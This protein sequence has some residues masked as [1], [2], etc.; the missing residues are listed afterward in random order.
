MVEF[1]CLDFGVLECVEKHPVTISAVSMFLSAVVVLLAARLA[2]RGARLQGQSALEAAQIQ[3]RSALDTA[4][5]QIDHQKAMQEKA[6]REEKLLIA[7]TMKSEIDFIL[8]QMA[9]LI[10][11]DDAPINHHDFLNFK[12]PVYEKFMGEI[13]ILGP[14]FVFSA[15]GFYS[16]LD[17]F[18]KRYG[19]SFNSENPQ[20]I[21][22]AFSLNR[23]LGGAKDDII[24][25]KPV[26]DF[27]SAYLSKAIADLG[28]SAVE[29]VWL[30]PQSPDQDP[31]P[32]AT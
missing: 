14:Q 16:L 19:I 30:I 3:A 8:A 12:F 28:G 18:N 6:E 15:T 26:A 10:E 13:S 11:S 22:D 21:M 25:M 32:T 23:S 31:G 2:Y 17:K 7:L 5:A 24:K 1:S 27:L 9:F 4:N 20:T 29:L